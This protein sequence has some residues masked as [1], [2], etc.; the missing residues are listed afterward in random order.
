MR[1]RVKGTQDEVQI[2][3]GVPLR[4]SETCTVNG[5]SVISRLREGKRRRGIE[6]TPEEGCL[7]PEMDKVTEGQN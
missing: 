7:I 2:W 4:L 5:G 1:A 6:E 3:L